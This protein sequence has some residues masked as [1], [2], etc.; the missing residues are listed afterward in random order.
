MFDGLKKFIG[1][2][3]VEIKILLDMSDN[4]LGFKNRGGQGDDSLDKASICH[5]SIRTS[6][7]VPSSYIKK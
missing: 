6:V 1:F 2:L 4:E 3:K 7:G 5:E